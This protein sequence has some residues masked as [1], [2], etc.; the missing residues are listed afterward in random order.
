MQATSYSVFD[1][2]CAV[3]DVQRRLRVDAFD[4]ESLRVV[5]H[6]ADQDA[7]VLFRRQV[8]GDVLD[9]VHDAN[10]ELAGPETGRVRGRRVPVVLLL[11]VHQHRPFARRADDQRPRVGAQRRPGQEMRI[12]LER[13][14]VVVEEHG[15]RCAG[16]DHGV[17][18]TGPLQRPLV[19]GLD[20]AQMV[21]VQAAERRAV[22]F[23][24]HGRHHNLRPRTA[25]SLSME[26]PSLFGNCSLL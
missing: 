6:F 25:A 19:A 23:G 26:R 21:G 13:V 3:Q 15:T 4:A 18:G 9:R 20:L 2:A 17:R 22:G 14:V 1:A 10:V 24:C 12:G 16:K 5:L 11:E 8:L 7:L